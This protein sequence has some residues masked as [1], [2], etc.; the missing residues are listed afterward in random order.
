MPDRYATTSCLGNLHKS[1][2]SK[3]NQNVFYYCNLVYQWLILALRYHVLETYH[4]ES[5]PVTLCS[6]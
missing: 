4:N 2:G 1:T 3:D 5:E 6:V